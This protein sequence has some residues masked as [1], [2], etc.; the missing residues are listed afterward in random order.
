MTYCDNEY[1]KYDEVLER[2][3]DC[4]KKYRSINIGDMENIKVVKKNV[5]NKDD[6]DNIEEAPNLIVLDKSEKFRDNDGNVYDIEV[7]GKRNVDKCFFRLE[8]VSDCFGIKSLKYNVTDKRKNGYKE[9]IH[10]KIFK[11]EYEKHQKELAHKET[12]LVKKDVEI[13]KKETELAKQEVTI[14]KMQAEIDKLKKKLKKTS[15][16]KK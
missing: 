4:F 16:H 8:D 7:R 15:K 1:Y 2:C 5:V 3:S 10:Y 9:N 6:L 11:V 12:E 13:S 14:A